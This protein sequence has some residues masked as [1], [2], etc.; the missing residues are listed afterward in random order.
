[1]AVILNVLLKEI[2]TGFLIDL[3]TD[4]LCIFIWVMI[5]LNEPRAGLVHSNYGVI[6]CVLSTELGTY[7][8]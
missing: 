2:Q 4:L 8:I 1:M 7:L 3:G 6:H 5:I